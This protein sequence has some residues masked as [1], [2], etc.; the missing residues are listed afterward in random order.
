MNSDYYISVQSGDVAII[1]GCESVLAYTEEKIILRLKKR[2]IT[3]LGGK[4]SMASYFGNEIKI[5][6]RIDAISFETGNVC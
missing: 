5:C 6:G 4:L 3:V 1:C 2:N